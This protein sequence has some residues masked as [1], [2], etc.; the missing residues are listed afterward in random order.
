MVKNV[1]RDDR[2]E[3]SGE[4]KRPVRSD[5]FDPAADIEASIEASVRRVRARQADTAITTF[6]VGLIGAYCWFSNYEILWWPYTLV[7][8]FGLSGALRYFTSE[9]LALRPKKTNPAQNPAFE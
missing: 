6:A 7:A 4:L 5:K 8:F 2:D 1:L 3:R 9:A